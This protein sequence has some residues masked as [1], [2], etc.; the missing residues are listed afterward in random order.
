MPKFLPVSYERNSRRGLLRSGASLALST[1]LSGCGGGSSGGGSR[2]GSG[3]GP[4]PTPSPLTNPQPMPTGFIMNTTA[5]VTTGEIGRIGSDFL[6]LSFEKSALVA[7]SLSISNPSLIARLKD[8]GPGIMRIGGATVDMVVWTPEGLGQVS[9]QVSKIDIDSFVRFVKETD[10]KVIYGI[11]LAQ[12][13]PDAAADEAAY[14]AQRLGSYLYCFELGN[15]PDLYT[16][17][18]IAPDK[19]KK[20]T[21]DLFKAKWDQLR[22]AIVTRVADATFCGPETANNLATYVVP[23]AKSLDKS[24]LKLLT[25]HH[26]RLHKTDPQTMDFLLTTPD[27]VLTQGTSKER[28]RLQVLKEVADAI[29]IPFRFTEANSAVGGGVVGISDVYVSALWSLDFLFVVAKG[30]GEGVHFHTGGAAN[31]SSIVFSQSQ[32][33]FLRPAYFSYLLFKMMGQ[34]PVLDATMQTGGGN[35]SVYAIKTSSGLS[36]LFVNKVT[37]ESYKVVLDLPFAPTKATVIHLHGPNFS[38]TTSVQLQGASLS[39][40]SGLGTMDAPYSVPVHEQKATL[41]VPALTAVLLKLV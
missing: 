33:S 14:A 31:Y 39:A 36:V 2:G 27:P 13:T 21:Y 41:Y 7:R 29:G 4:A 8:I 9:N 23:F 30:G 25:Q 40:T 17:V 26:Y 12:N 11:N 10:W 16:D 32:I 24:K 34:G 3:G 20:W 28:A 15:E 18:Y 38:A 5:R 19:T 37:N 35:A 22:T 6:G 1:F